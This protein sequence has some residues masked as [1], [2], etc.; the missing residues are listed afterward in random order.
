MY[1]SIHKTHTFLHT[2][3][4]K[5]ALHKRSYRHNRFTCLSKQKVGKLHLGVL[6]SS[7]MVHQQLLTPFHSMQHLFMQVHSSGAQ[8]SQDPTMH[9]PQVVEQISGVCDLALSREGE[10]ITIQSS[11]SHQRAA[12]TYAL[13]PSE[14]CS[15]GS[16]QISRTQC[17]YTCIFLYICVCICICLHMNMSIYICICQYVYVYVNMYMYIYIYRERERES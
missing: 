1:A 11:N 2:H 15:G 3:I 17:G 7:G 13:H 5:H 10:N 4:Q 16:S 12:R 9:G 6:Y 8:F 14:V